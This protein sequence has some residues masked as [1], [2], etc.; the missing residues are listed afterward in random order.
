MHNTNVWC[1]MW[2]PPANHVSGLIVAVLANGQGRSTA[3]KK[4]FEVGDSTMVDIRIGCFKSPAIGVV[5]KRE[6]HVF[7]DPLLEIYAKSPI[8]THDYIAT[9]AT[10]AG[11]IA[12]R[13][14]QGLVRAVIAHPNGRSG[15]RRLG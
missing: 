6:G 2:K 5:V 8:G 7:V 13:I 3:R 10:V 1:S 15:K 12:A 9:H 14:V 11:Y 4:M